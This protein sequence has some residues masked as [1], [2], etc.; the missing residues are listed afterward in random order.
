MR[1]PKHTLK[2]L[3]LLMVFSVAPASGHRAVIVPTPAVVSWSDDPVACPYERARLA[4]AAAAAS[5]KAEPTTITLTDRIPPDA[6]LLGRGSGL[7][8]P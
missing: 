8:L 4:A 1:M 6:P 5:D 2:L 7:F 3:V